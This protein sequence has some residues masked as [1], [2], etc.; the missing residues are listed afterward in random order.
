MGLPPIP[1]AQISSVGRAGF[2]STNSTR[3]EKAPVVTCRVFFFPPA[4]AFVIIIVAA[5]S[6]HSIRYSLRRRFNRIDRVFDIVLN[7]NI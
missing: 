6:H 1:V 5:I 4:V 7:L 3:A 2:A